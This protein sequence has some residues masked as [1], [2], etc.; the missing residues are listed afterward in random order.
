MFILVPFTDLNLT[1]QPVFVPVSSGVTFP[2]APRYNTTAP[3][4][5]DKT[6]LVDALIALTI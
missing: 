5:V 4:P 2:S 1:V 6:A 3:S